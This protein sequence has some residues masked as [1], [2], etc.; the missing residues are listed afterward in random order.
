MLH[1]RHA[2]QPLQSTI[3][4]IKCDLKTPFK[5]RHIPNL[6]SKYILKGKKLNICSLRLGTGT[7]SVIREENERKG[8]YMYVCM[9]TYVCALCTRLVFMEARRGHC[10]PPNVVLETEPGSSEEQQA[11]LTAEPPFQPETEVLAV[12]GPSSALL[13]AW[14]LFTSK[15]QGRKDPARLPNS[16]FPVAL[17]QRSLLLRACG[18]TASSHGS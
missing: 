3:K 13:D 9:C 5:K 8:K 15:R 17:S 6:Y 11:L 7:A 12:A 14:P 4:I 18:A 10:E 16:N 2:S 1:G